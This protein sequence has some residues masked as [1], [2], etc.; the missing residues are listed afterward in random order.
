MYFIIK[1]RI[2]MKKSV[3]LIS[4]AMALSVISAIPFS[5]DAAGASHDGTYANYIQLD[6]YAM[7]AEE[8]ENTAVTLSSYVRGAVKEGLVIT[9]AQSGVTADNALYMR[10]LVDMS[11]TV[12]EK[13]YSCLGQNFTT[14]YIPFCFGKLS[15]GVYS[16]NSF[17]YMG[18][19]E[20]MEPVNGGAITYNGNDTVKFSIP[21]R[22]YVNEDGELAQDSSSHTLIVPLEIQEDGSAT[23]TFKY[24]DLYYDHAEVATAVGV[25]PYY[26]P[27][28]LEVGSKIPDFNNKIVWTA[29][30]DTNTSFL[31]NSDDFPLMQTS[32]Y[33][34]K[35]SPCGIYNIGFEEDYCSITGAVNG[36]SEHLPMKY[37][38]AAI[39]VGV[40]SASLR[41]DSG[42]P[43]YACFF[44]DDEKVITGAKA[45]YSYICDVTYSDGTSETDK[46]VTGAVNAGVSPAELFAGTDANYYA[47]NVQMLC[48]DTPIESGTLKVL[49]GNKGDVNFDGKAD[50]SDAGMVLEYYAK[51]S[52]GIDASFTDNTN[53][54]LEI[55][56]FFLAD[57]D[58]ESQT[59]AAGGS[60]DL[61]DASA[62]LS[63]YANAAAGNIVTWDAYLK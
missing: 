39:A 28:L 50:L 27:E 62:I 9:S 45:G 48:G 54:Y 25:I 21:G 61:S 37:S 47:D 49:A 38:G 13:T 34:K 4:L 43:M 57:I 42:T 6:R 35:G 8:A 58:T 36:K 55:L 7:T 24:A 52:S 32:V 59:G 14:G 56:A 11:K 33:L 19:S 63:Y 29:S 15:G 51:K 44:A 3:K 23:Y 16:T 60:L 10:D 22:F 26:Q 17:M 20:C 5:A 2:F 18:R 31:G 12:S 53:E 40:E 30:V 1:R 46:D 41:T